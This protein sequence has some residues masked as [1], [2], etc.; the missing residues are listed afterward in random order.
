MTAYTPN[1]WKKGDVISSAKLNNI[2]T[3]I[4]KISETTEEINAAVKTLNTSVEEVTKSVET[5][6][7]TT[8]GFNT[9]IT[10]TSTNVADIKT[11]IVTIKTAINSITGSITDI[12]DRLANLE[13][14]VRTLQ[15]TN[16][17]EVT[18]P[19]AQ[20]SDTTADAV[21]KDETITGKASGITAKTIALNG[22]LAEDAAISLKAI[23][24]ITM[25]D[26]T[27]TGDLEKSVSNAAWSINTD[28][29]VVIRN[30]IFEQTGYNC[31]EIGLSSTAPKSVL[32]ED[33]QFGDLNNNAILIFA[34]KA[35]ATITIRNCTFG[36]ISQMLRVSNRTNVSGVKV[37][38][39]NC[40][41][42]K[43]G[44]ENKGRFILG[45]D[46]TSTTV[47]E[48]TAA[49]RFGK[50][51][52]TFTLTNVTVDGKLVTSSE[53]IFENYNNATKTD[54]AETE[55]DKFPTFIIQ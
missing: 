51:K 54:I 7:T 40:A 5:L 23:G 4:Q 27:T 48:V 46:Y 29:E 14:T 53:G 34:T 25:S 44:E 32:I 47:D 26:V 28:D 38:L 39:I 55:T 6:T 33:C 17:I 43:C 22:T 49:N 19:S 30:C 20:F 37:N 18:D 52:F 31:V 16:I 1:T 50:D 10:E 24:S 35:N 12:P 8:D 45:Q 41:V 9:T 2:E 15:K 21:V 36:N 42:A 13:D 11:S 3:G